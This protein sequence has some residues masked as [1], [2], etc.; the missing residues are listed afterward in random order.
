MAIFNP[1]RSLIRRLLLFL[2]PFATLHVGLIF[3]RASPTSLE[4]LS[5][6]I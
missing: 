2:S 5:L 1:Y 4:I 3:S 6:N